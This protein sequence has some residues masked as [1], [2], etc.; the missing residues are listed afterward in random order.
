MNKLFYTAFL[1]SVFSTVSLAQSNSFGTHQAANLDSIGQI[2]KGQI[3]I[4]GDSKMG[5]SEQ[6]KTDNQ[7]PLSN[8][9]SE[10]RTMD[11]A[12]PKKD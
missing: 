1:L 4:K 10:M 8:G 3:V 5:N 11:T 9:K 7:T 2:K 12:S 6:V